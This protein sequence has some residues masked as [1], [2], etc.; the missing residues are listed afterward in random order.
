MSERS[1]LFLAT[2]LPEPTERDVERQCDRLVMSIGGTDAVVRRSPPHKFMGTP[3]IPDRRYRLW[4]TAFDFEVKKPT[5]ELSNAQVF[6]LREEIACGNLAGAG[7]V[8]ELTR[9]VFAIRD[10]QHGKLTYAQLVDAIGATVEE[11]VAKRE[12][13]RAAVTARKA[14]RLRKR[15][16][17]ICEKQDKIAVASRGAQPNTDNEPKPEESPK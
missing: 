3:G 17:K 5:G 4:R 13:E 14:E 8:D 1:I 6:Y 11:W 12:A 15:V 16:L 10:A 2:H 7:G 9:C